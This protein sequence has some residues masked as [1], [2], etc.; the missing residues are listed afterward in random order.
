M[1]NFTVDQQ[2]TLTRIL[3]GE[4]LRAVFNERCE[5]VTR[6]QHC[7]AQDLEHDPDFLP[8]EAMSRIAAAIEQLPR[9]GKP[10]PETA[11]RYLVIAGALIFAAIDRIDRMPAVQSELFD[12]AET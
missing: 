6:K 12:G 8:K 2:E 1:N 4:A 9:K 10:N 7:D 3:R 11:R 5:Q